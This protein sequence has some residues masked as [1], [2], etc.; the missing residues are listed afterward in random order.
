MIIEVRVD[1]C[2]VFSN[3]TKLS[4]KADMRNKKFAYNV[5]SHS[6][7][8][9][10]KSV[11]LYGPNNVGKTCLINAIRYIRRVMLNRR[12]LGINPNL[13]TKNE[14]CKL[15][16]TFM[17]VDQVF[18]FDFHY[19]TK[20]EEFVYEKF[21][22]IIRDKYG[23]EKETIYLEKDTV[24]NKIVV[25][26][27]DELKKILDAVGKDNIAIYLIDTEKF[28]QLDFIKKVLNSF[29]KKIDVVNMNNIPTTKTLEIFKKK[30]SKQKQIVEFIKK[31]D[32]DI[33]D[34]QYN[35]DIL[36]KMNF[37]INGNKPE[38]QE[39]VLKLKDNFIDQFCLVSVHKG[40]PVPSMLFDSTG[41][42]K[43]VALASY[44]IEAIE[45][46]KI[47]VVDEL[48][49]S[50]HFSLTRAIV[51]L[52]NNELNKD[53]QLIFS[54]HDISLLD[55]KKLFRKEQIWFM[56]RTE[57]QVY[58]YSLSE[59]T[60]RSTGTRDTSDIMEQYK[61]GVYGALPHPDLI[62][63]LLEVGK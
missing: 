30:S 14:I 38:P 41:T 49:S 57:K 24:N 47:I 51:S 50:L 37:K 4:L 12:P 1:N 60:A 45:A 52:L 54:A 55:C 13:F 15:G 11:C 5:A 62:E 35:K 18:S 34:F 39:E 28:P 33:D 26:N 53:G 46:G 10:L 59:F 36:K 19:N 42:K 6:N 29:A 22:E 48:D 3:S 44:I 20:K 16:M 32:I 17:Q 8:N 40:V 2:Q 61:K 56:H 21:S 63:A 9:I 58:L 23:N 27:N 25:Q 43:I 31:A 7:F